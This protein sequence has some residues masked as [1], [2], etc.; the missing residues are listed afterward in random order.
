MSN[1]ALA[2]AL[3]TRRINEVSRLPARKLPFCDEHHFADPKVRLRFNHRPGL[4]SH[5]V[6]P[7]PGR[8]VVRSLCEATNYE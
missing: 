4:S 5:P 1:S 3:K 7:S 8:S 2:V 6:P